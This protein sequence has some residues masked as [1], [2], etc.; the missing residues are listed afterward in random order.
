MKL[1]D[2]DNVG[3]IL[4]LKAKQPDCK[5]EEQFICVANTHLLFNKRR[6]DI[7]LA[8]IAYLFAEINELSLLTKDDHSKTHCPIIL[9]GDLNSLPYSPLYNFL[10]T[11]QLEYCTRC[12][13]ALSGQLPPSETRYRPSTRRIQP[14]LLPWEFG[15]SADC[16]WRE[17]KPEGCSTRT[18]DKQTFR[19]QEATTCRTQQRK[20][21]EDWNDHH[22]SIQPN[23]NT[24]GT[25]TYME[26][27]LQQ[28]NFSSNIDDRRVNK[29]SE[30][31]SNS[32]RN[33]FSKDFSGQLRR[34]ENISLNVSS[35]RDVTFEMKRDAISNNPCNRM[36]ESD[37]NVNISSIADGTTFFK[38][39]KSNPSK[40]AEK[41][42]R[43]SE[44]IDLTSDM[45]SPDPCNR[46]SNS[47]RENIP[48]VS[49]DTRLPARV[50][51]NP[52]RIVDKSETHREIV[53]LTNNTVSPDPCN[54]VSYSYRNGMADRFRET[55]L[56]TE[57]KSKPDRIV[58]KSGRTSEFINLTGDTESPS[59]HGAAP[60]TSRFDICDRD[61]DT[62]RSNTSR[63]A[64]E[65]HSDTLVPTTSTSHADMQ[66]E[67]KKYNNNGTIYI[68]WH[69]KSV[70]THRFRDGS[71]EVTTCHSKACCNVDYIFYSTGTRDGQPRGHVQTGKLTLLGRLELLRKSDITSMRVLPNDTFPSDHLSL[72]ARFKLT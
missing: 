64:W 33:E 47:K 49:K 72:K 21:A 17:D 28:T 5:T 11:G 39:T 59:P 30:Q 43:N 38:Q 70:Y 9:C 35:N 60:E 42:E 18:Q 34:T 24:K 20:N 68:P 1:L 3:I 63:R 2:K 6:G 14:P 22:E 7:K 66:T 71:P 69:L 55:R 23:R 8:Q 12:P 25:C 46:V 50:T 37:K 32:A 41:S 65:Q 56:F 45:E 67:K 26:S 13:A 53:D 16:Q 54:S 58:D 4:L 27:D 62:N 29:D 51:S 19:L 40:I 61:R 10:I 52:K 57:T 44:V 48:N 15:V 36:R 31:Q